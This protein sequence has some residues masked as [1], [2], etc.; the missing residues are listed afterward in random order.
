[1]YELFDGLGAYHE[2]NAL[3]SFRMLLEYARLYLNTPLTNFLVIET[4][5]SRSHKQITRT[6]TTW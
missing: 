2:K 5:R 3:E 6:G 1:M 4:E